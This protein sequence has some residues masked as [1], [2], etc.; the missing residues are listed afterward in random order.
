MKNLKNLYRK[1]IALGA[2][3][4][5]LGG[6]SAP[7]LAQDRPLPPANPGKFKINYIAEHEYEAQLDVTFAASGSGPNWV[8]TG[9]LIRP[10]G[11]TVILGTL[12]KKLGGY[13][14]KF[15]NYLS[16]SSYDVYEGAIRAKV[17]WS[18]TGTTSVQFMAGVVTRYIKAG[19]LIL[20]FGPMPFC[21]HVIEVPNPA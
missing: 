8:F 7:A 1:L 4:A 9:L 20:P 5:A 14:I 21:A 13:Y 6:L 11:K 17:T 2:A 18:T 3:C 12:T 15:K 16:P 10:E 19:G